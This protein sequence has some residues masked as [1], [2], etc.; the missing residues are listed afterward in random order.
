MT[1]ELSRD[2]MTAR[3]P[4]LYGRRV[5]L[6]PVV[7]ADYEFLFTLSTSPEITYRWRTRGHTPSPENF[8][9]MLWDGVLCQFI[10]ERAT[11]GEPL[12]L[13]T[14]YNADFRNQTAYLAVLAKER[15]GNPL[16]TLDAL[17]LFLNY[18]FLTWNFRKI[19]AET[20]ELSS[21]TFASGAGR[22]FQVEGT[23]R[24]HEYYDG[25]YWDAYLL[26]IWRH[27][28]EPLFN[29]LLPAILPPGP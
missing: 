19:Y 23:L 26:A 18:L 8:Q 24:E 13:I 27:D 6:R 14:A 16:W 3:P 12:G 10:I 29:D 7:P 15:P 28:C 5:A 17:I 4:V 20:S 11:D 22:Y 9:S 21:W 25:R 2:G 1:T